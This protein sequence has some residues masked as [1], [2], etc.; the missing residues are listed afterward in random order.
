MVPRD[1][2]GLESSGNSVY[3]DEQPCKTH[4]L[5]H[6]TNPNRKDRKCPSKSVSSVARRLCRMRPDL[7]RTCSNKDHAKSMQVQERKVVPLYTRVT[8]VPLVVTLDQSP[9]DVSAQD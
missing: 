8:A 3:S 2:L 5:A 9:T 7:H 1:K 4:L 6:S